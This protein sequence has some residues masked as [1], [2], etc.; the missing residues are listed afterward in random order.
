LLQLQ[1]QQIEHQQGLMAETARVAALAASIEQTGA[2]M[3]ALQQRERGDN[4]TEIN[5]A[6]HQVYLL[7]QSHHQSVQRQRRYQLRAPIDGSVQELQIHTV[8]GI[9]S[10][11]Q[12]LL[13]LIPG[14]DA[15]EI[16]AFVR[17]RDIGFVHEGQ[18]TAVKVDTF[19]FTRYGTL[20]GKLKILSSD[21][22]DKQGLGLVY[23]ATVELASTSLAVEHKRVSLAPG[24]A[25]TV[26]IKTGSRRIIEFF[27]SPLLKLGSES[28]HER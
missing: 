3:A 1:Q 22:I 25:V 6:R 23:P 2:R 24:M 18:T 19:I 28:L 15:L 10:P 26:E 16:E 27:L 21:A 20:E 12:P 17:N 11:A 14:N 9:V 4:L 5:R 8:G 13:T 7:T